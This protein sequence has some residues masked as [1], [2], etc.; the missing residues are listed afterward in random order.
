MVSTAQCWLQVNATTE[1]RYQ[2]EAALGPP[3]STTL[4][5]RG[6]AEGKEEEKAMS[7]GS[8]AHTFG[9][10]ENVLK[11]IEKEKCSLRCHVVVVLVDKHL[12]NHTSA[13]V[14]GA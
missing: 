9:L 13:L 14:V 2:R 1:N 3:G 6:D 8:M 4:C 7:V 11:R 5:A 12:V 10:L